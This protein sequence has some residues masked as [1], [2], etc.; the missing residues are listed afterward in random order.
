MYVSRTA[1]EER[2]NKVRSERIN[3]M[4]VIHSA[5]CYIFEEDLA[6]CRLLLLSWLRWNGDT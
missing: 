2:I 4:A 1:C 6:K 5:L 3:L